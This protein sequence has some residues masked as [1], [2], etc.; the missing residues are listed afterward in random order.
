MM[1]EPSRRSP[2]GLNDVVGL[3]GLG[4]LAYGLWWI[5]WPL[6]FVVPGAVLTAVALIGAWP[7][8]G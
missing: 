2:V 7:R 5:Y 6:A 1:P 4:L 3:V 8:R